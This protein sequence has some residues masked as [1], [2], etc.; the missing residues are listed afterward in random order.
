MQRT[1][2]VSCAV[3]FALALL[4]LPLRAGAQEPEIL[5]APPGPDFGSVLVGDVSTMTVTVTN[6]DGYLTI[7]SLE[8]V[9]DPSLVITAM[10]RPL[11]AILAGGESMDVEIAFS[12]TDVGPV[13][14]DIEVDIGTWVYSAT[15]TGEGVAP[16]DPID[17]LLAFF[18]AAVDDGTL[19][20]VGP[21]CAAAAHLWVMR[22]AIELAGHKLDRGRTACACVSLAFAE[23]RSDGDPR[24]RDLVEGPAAPDLAAALS[25]VMDAIGCP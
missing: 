8:L 17:A 14:A 25:D 10:S 4:A 22:S 15:I 1:V 19:V 12:P 21:H 5:F 9:G 2:S 13:S 11:P 23:R 16:G 7:G 6:N 3:V 18:D 20:G 24:P